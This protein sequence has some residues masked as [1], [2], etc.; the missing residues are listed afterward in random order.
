MENQVEC[1]Q[2]NNNNPPLDEE[3]AITLAQLSN[4]RS[5]NPE[6]QFPTGK[7]KRKPT[8]KKELMYTVK[9][10]VSETS[11][12]QAPSDRSG[13]NKSHKKQKGDEKT[14]PPETKSPAMIRAEEVQ[15]NLEPDLPSF[16]K[17]LVRSHV[18]SCF[19]MGL[20]GPFCKTHLPHEDGTVTLEDENGNEFKIKY[21]A[22]KTGLSAGWRQFCMAHNL[23]EGD[24]LI[25][26]L[27]G[28]KRFKVYIIRAH[29]MSELDGALGLLN[30][31]AQ[32]T[33]NDAEAVSASRKSTKKKRKSLPLANMQKE[34]RKS[35]KHKS[36]APFK[37]MPQAAEQS[38]IDSEEIGSEVLEGHKLA[39]PTFQFNDVKSLEDFCILVDGLVIDSELQDNTRDKYYDLCCSQ[40]A[41]L[42]ENLIPGINY[43]LIIGTISE[44]V[45]I[46]NALASCKLTTSREE[47]SGWE[48]SL[49]AFE[50]LGM[51]IGFLHSRLCQLANLALES[52]GASFT[53]RYMEAK[54]ERTRAEEEIKSLEEKHEELK[55]ASEKYDAELKRL[56]T[57]ADCYE[58][59]F[60]DE[61]TAPW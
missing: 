50:L 26:Q 41:F 22:Y 42:H 59:K 6:N 1:A 5:P 2:A 12:K 57:K 32:I 15:M 45:S 52:E 29:D 8:E 51:K 55:D 9:K 54:I 40:N 49:K 17:S 36:S 3:E 13:K 14:T 23:L 44:T 18:G 25:F 61:V 4:Q 21:I 31:E 39:T 24:V 34:N 27:I 60:Q 47:F 33:Q 20:P 35:R 11:V 30:L 53:R 19:W 58:L 10:S 16:A 48:R 56:K 38:E 28:P 46:A 7:R 43:K 37:N